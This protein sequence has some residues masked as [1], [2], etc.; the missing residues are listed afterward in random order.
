MSKQLIRRVIAL[1]ENRLELLLVELQEE[2]ERTLQALLLALASG[3]L[4]LL[5]GIVFSTAVVLACWNIGPVMILSGLCIIYMTLGLVALR[6]LSQSLKE[7]DSLAGTRDQ[8][9]KDREELERF[10]R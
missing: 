9:R 8:L 10:I 1:G 3:A 7:W 2:R 5:G 6:R 4:F